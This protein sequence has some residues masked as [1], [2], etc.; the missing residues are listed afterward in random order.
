MTEC[1]ILPRVLGGWHDY[2]FH[3]VEPQQSVSTIQLNEE[4]R[5]KAVFDHNLCKAQTS[6]RRSRHFTRIPLARRAN[7][8]EKRSFSSSSFHSSLF[9]LLS[10]LQSIALLS[11]SLPRSEQRADGL[12]VDNV[13]EGVGVFA[14]GDDD[15]PDYRNIGVAMKS[16]KSLSLAAKKFLDYLKYRN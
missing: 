9:T 13:V 12:A 11:P 16:R 5:R 10:S 3:T 6:R 14:V 15:V 4:N 7:F 1:R 8:T 2:C